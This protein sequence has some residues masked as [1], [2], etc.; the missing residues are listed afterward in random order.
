MVLG[1]AV[2]DLSKRLLECETRGAGCDAARGR[3]RKIYLPKGPTS[4]SE[5]ESSEENHPS[6]VIL[7]QLVAKKWGGGQAIGV[8]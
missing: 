5:S 1:P 6:L 8:T 2:G 4:I 7:L 3:K